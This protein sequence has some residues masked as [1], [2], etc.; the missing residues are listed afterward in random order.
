[1]PEP[2]HGTGRSLRDRTGRPSHDHGTSLA[3]PFR[4]GHKE[5]KP[6]CMEDEV[7]EDDSILLVEDNPDDV[8][9]ITRAL[10]KTG[11]GGEVVI[12]SDGVEALDRLHGGETLPRLVL[13]D[14]RLPKLDGFRVLRRLREHDRTRRLPVVLL[15]SYE[16]EREAL[17]GELDADFYLPKAVD[18]GR[19]LRDLRRIKPL[20]AGAN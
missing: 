17:A 2:D 1:M 16:G 5:G 9:L 8:L 12:A 10:R 18:F 11:V 6:I 20:L 7:P 3:A 19:F 14:P 15:T 13:L 4:P